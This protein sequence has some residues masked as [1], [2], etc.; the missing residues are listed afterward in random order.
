MELLGKI[1]SG[2]ECETHTT[3]MLSRLLTGEGIAA[4]RKNQL[5]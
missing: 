2:F 1:I 3:E 4:F 5:W